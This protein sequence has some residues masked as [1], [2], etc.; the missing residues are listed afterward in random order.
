MS[1]ANIG[2]LIAIGCNSIYAVDC[3]SK[4]SAVKLSRLRKNKDLRSCVP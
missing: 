1:D 4:I 2:E 3:N